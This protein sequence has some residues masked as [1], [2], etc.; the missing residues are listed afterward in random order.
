M[1]RCL[2]AGQK[3]EVCAKRADEARLDYANMGIAGH[4]VVGGEQPEDWLDAGQ[5]TDCFLPPFNH[6][7]G[8]SVQY[9]L[10]ISRFD[11]DPAHPARFHW[12]FIGS[13]RQS[14]AR[15]RAPATSSSTGA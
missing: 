6:R 14:P 7:P 10:A 15:V 13:S 11:E 5:C 1:E 4:L 8:T 12:G 9:G 2:K 3:E